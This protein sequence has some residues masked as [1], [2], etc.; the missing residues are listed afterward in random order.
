MLFRSAFEELVARI[1]AL[2]RRRHG[3][4]RSVIRVDDLVVNLAERRVTRGGSG[5][6]LT[7]REYAILEFLA[8]RE[9]RPVS[10]AALEEHIYD[11]AS[12]VQSNAIDSAICSLRA[13]LNA[14]GSR[15]SLIHT[16]RGVGYVLSGELA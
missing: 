3:E 5:V 1:E 11:E 10:R 7:P 8:H 9:G 13:K 6:E 14:C 2:A 15:R 4:A 16:R 12:Q